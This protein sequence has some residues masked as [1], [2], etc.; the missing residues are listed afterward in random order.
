ME[1]RRIWGCPWFG[2]EDLRPATVAALIYVDTLCF[3]MSVCR[4]LR[5][6]VVDRRINIQLAES[7][8]ERSYNV[9]ELYCHCFGSAA[10]DAVD[11]CPQD[12]QDKRG[13]E[14]VLKVCRGSSTK[15][16]KSGWCGLWIDLGYRKPLLARDSWNHQLPIGKPLR[17][18][19]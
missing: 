4:N 16:Q 5:S 12:R 17:M 10:P 11:C 9:S 13:R 14:I 8:C 19:W 7:S 3:V 6:D 18:S 15:A 2:V 1:V